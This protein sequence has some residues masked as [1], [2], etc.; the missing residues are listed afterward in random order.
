MAR[1][2][3]LI[4]NGN[5]RLGA[6]GAE[7]ARDALVAAGFDVLRFH[8]AKDEREFESHL[9]RS[10]RDAAPL[11]GIGGGD[12]TMRT[13]AAKLAD[14]VCTL[15]PVPLG[16][17]NSWARELGI[18]VSLP[19]MAQALAKGEE[20]NIDVGVVNGEAFINVATVG[21][22]SLIVKNMDDSAKGR[23]GRLAYFPA[24]VK[25]ILQ[26]RPFRLRVETEES[27]FEGEALLFVAAAG[28]THAGPFQVTKHAENDDGMLSLYALHGDDWR[29]LLRFGYA[30]LR[31]RHTT[32]EEVW[33]TETARASVTS[34]PRRRSIVDGDRGPRTPLSLTV[35]AGSLRVLAP[36]L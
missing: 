31:G 3:V 25:S 29:G 16:T 26:V 27:C 8:V 4:C 32:L 19:E 2:L 20:R 14:S 1:E 23:L 10:I 9:D 6:R 11:I 17:G 30:M 33:C 12:G 18:P 34:R 28:R 15:L 22:T 24:V 35:R 36:K 21:V 7:S 5:A 13:A